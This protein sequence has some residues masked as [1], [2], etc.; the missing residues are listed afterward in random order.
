VNIVS[1]TGSYSLRLLCC[2]LTGYNYIA[3]CEHYTTDQS[4]EKLEQH[5][6]SFDTRC[7]TVS[8]LFAPLPCST[9]CAEQGVCPTDTA[10]LSVSEVL[11]THFMFKLL[12]LVCTNPN[13][14]HVLCTFLLIEADSNTFLQVA[15]GDSYLATMAY[16]VSVAI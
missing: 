16:T 14:S 13:M 3:Q 5:I 6:N 1:E 9:K 12:C 4:M 10:I 11:N 2:A 15:T 8:L 7:T